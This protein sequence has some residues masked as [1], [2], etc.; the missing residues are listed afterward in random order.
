MKALTKISVISVMAAG[1][2]LGLAGC[3]AG[4]QHQALAAG[5]GALGGAALGYAL[6]GGSTE[7]AIAGAGVGGVGGA[8]LSRKVQG[9]F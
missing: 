4:D 2:S 3:A 7:A 9:K 8:L 1:I 5:G 6:S